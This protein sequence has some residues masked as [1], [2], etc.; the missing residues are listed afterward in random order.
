MLPQV[1][2][3]GEADLSSAETHHLG[4]IHGAKVFMFTCDR[5]VHTHLHTTVQDYILSAPVG[6][7]PPQFVSDLNAKMKDQLQPLVFY[8][9]QGI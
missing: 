5:V 3:L 6:L 7:S 9:T 8:L 1:W 4:N 2:K